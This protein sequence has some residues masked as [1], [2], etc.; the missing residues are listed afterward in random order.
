MAPACPSPAPQSCSPTGARQGPVTQSRGVLG[1]LS[2]TAGYFVCRAREQ[3]TRA[4]VSCSTAA[5]G[6]REAGQ[7]SHLALLLSSG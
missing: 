1:E 6:V 2:V 4:P 7:D 5:P 3:R